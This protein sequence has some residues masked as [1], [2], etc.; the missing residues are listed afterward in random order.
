MVRLRSSEKTEPEWRTVI[1]ADAEMRP[2]GP[3]EFEL[4]SGEGRHYESP[5]L[6]E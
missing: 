3:A 1:E 2:R 5:N 6:A 4:P